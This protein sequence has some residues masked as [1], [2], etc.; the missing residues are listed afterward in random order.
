[1]EN[2]GKGV[3]SKG[4]SVLSSLGLH[5]D[6]VGVSELAEESGLPVSTTH[7]LLAT[8]VEHGYA[9]VDAE[10]RYR[11]GLQVFELSQRLMASWGND[12]VYD[13]LL[14]L[15]DRTGESALVGIRDGSEMVYV[16]HVEGT[17][18]PRVRGSVGGRGALYATAMGKALLASLPA[19]DL[20][21]VLDGIS[22]DRWAPKT[23]TSR[24]HLE[25]EI[26]LT[27]SRGFALADE[28]NERD[29]RSIAVLIT[30]PA[31][32]RGTAAVSIGAPVYRVSSDQL[33]EW[34]PLLQEAAREIGLIM[35]GVEGH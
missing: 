7:R 6:G 5:P 9:S 30:R 28:E 10:R 13:V 23:I 29:I 1:M 32:G 17:N 11:L 15:V 35:P 22:L 12:R 14:R 3:L 24:D 27:R 20:T 33:L 31:S 18:N 16:Q 4:L 26:A 19:R 34:L 21:A 2:A 8:L 25:R